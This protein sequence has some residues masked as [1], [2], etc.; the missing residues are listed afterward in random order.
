MFHYAEL[1]FP[2]RCMGEPNR[3]LKLLQMIGL[4]LPCFHHT[5]IHQAEKQSVARGLFSA[6]QMT[7]EEIRAP[8][9]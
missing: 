5:S 6:A 1:P 4:E 2:L 8:W 9:L 3:T 7:V